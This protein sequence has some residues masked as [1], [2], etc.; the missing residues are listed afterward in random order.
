MPCGKRLVI[1]KKIYSSKRLL[2]TDG[3]NSIES[4]K[5]KES[6]PYALFHVH[7]S[8][9]PESRKKSK[10]ASGSEQRQYWQSS[11]GRRHCRGGADRKSC[12]VS[13]SEFLDAVPGSQFQLTKQ[14]RPQCVT[15]SS[16]EIEREM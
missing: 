14:G 2:E 1:S 13:N 9:I 15:N 10:K 5:L 11:A 7:V 16:L 6:L 4:S 3:M 12:S 8:E